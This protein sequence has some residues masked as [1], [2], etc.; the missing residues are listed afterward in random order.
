[1]ENN[2]IE[3]YLYDVV[4]RLPEKQRKDI[5]E[6]LRTLIEDMLEERPGDGGAEEVEAVL[7]ELGDPAKLAMKYRGEEA[8]LIGGEYYPIYC[9]ILKLVLICVG[10][11][12]AISAVV[13]WIVQLPAQEEG[14]NGVV[15][16]VVDGFV[17]LGSLPEALLAAFGL[18]SWKEIR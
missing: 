2:L 12:V 14:M 1:M 5:E 13:H 4:R 8:H 15:N 7:S 16:G 6:E 3:R 18:L 10:V 11:G 9:Q 17:S